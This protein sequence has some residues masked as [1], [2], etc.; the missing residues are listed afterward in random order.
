MEKF[1]PV[2]TSA[3]VKKINIE[4]IVYLEQR[5]RRLA[6]ITQD[7]TYVCYER[8]ESLERQLDERFYYSLK[9]LVVNLEKIILAKNQSITFQNGDRIMLGRESYIRTKQSYAAYL[10]KLL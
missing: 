6:V 10:R 7:E 8:I 5:Q 4:D 1:V 2:I 3:Y 9:K